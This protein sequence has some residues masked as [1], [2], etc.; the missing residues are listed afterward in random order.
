MLHVD[1]SYLQ[2]M[3]VYQY[4]SVFMLKIFT[5][6]VLRGYSIHQHFHESLEKDAVML[7]DSVRIRLFLKPLEIYVDLVFHQV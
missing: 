4:S 2:E 6:V 5:Y 1:L 3:I 7:K